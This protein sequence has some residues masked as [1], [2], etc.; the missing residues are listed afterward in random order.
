MEKPFDA[1]IVGAGPAGSACAY[2][3]AQA[4]LEVL[5]VERGK[6]AG[7]KNMWGGAFYGP[8]LSELIP[9]FW[10][11]APYERYVSYRKISALSERASLSLEFKTEKFSQQPYNGIILLRSKFDRWLA[12]KAEKA[13]AILACGLQ[14]ENLIW[15][16]NSVA[17]IKAGGDEIRSNVVVA[18]DG[19]NSLLAQEAGLRAKFEPREV[20]QGV[21]EVLQ[22]PTQE[23]E[24]RFNLK[25]NEGLAWEFFGSFTEGMPGGA[26][27]YT[28]KDSLSVG[29]VVQLNA[30]VEKQQTISEV[31]DRFKEHKTV[32]KFLE[33]GRLMEYSAHLIPIQ[34]LGKTRLYSNG[35]LVAG[36]AASFVLATGLI[37]E[38]A[39]FALASG[40]AAATA[41]IRAKEQNNFSAESLSLYEKILTSSFVL[42]D[43]KTFN[44][45]ASI[46][47]NERLYQAYPRLACDFVEKLLT[48][49]GKPR[50]HVWQLF[51]ES[52]KEKVSTYDLIKDILKGVRGL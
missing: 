22:L 30:L 40:I 14:A 46:L 45:V 35:I 27:I 24:K 28:N 25:G 29:V 49:D 5:L 36:D 47:E 39:N 11:E 6:F 12:G 50:K 43:L 7:A 10:E 51:K 23:I 37:L 52:K 26:F 8:G 31:L 42:K 34:P 2:H 1:I 17:G 9:D 3:L 18:C 13:G 44:Q 33:D 19:V 48:N 20:K 38:G 4:G 32:T 16:G 15:D 41:V 21:K